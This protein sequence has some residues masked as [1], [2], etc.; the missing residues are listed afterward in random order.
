MKYSDSQGHRL[1]LGQNHVIKHN[2]E[3]GKHDLVKV[4]QEEEDDKVVSSHH[5]VS[6]ALDSARMSVEKPGK[7]AEEPGSHPEYQK[8]VKATFPSKRKMKKSEGMFKAEQEAI[9]EY[10][11]L[12]KTEKEDPFIYHRQ[13][14]A[15][16][17]ATAQHHWD[18]YEDDPKFETSRE[19]RNQASYHEQQAERHL[20]SAKAHHDPKKHGPWNSTI[21][22]GNIIK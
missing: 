16:H 3:T 22:K 9:I 21:P 19:H 14:A 8:Y 1:H 15:N 18:R 13:Q 7:L 4:G 5:T 6:G 17:G 11:K 2:K 12:T 20:E 10:A